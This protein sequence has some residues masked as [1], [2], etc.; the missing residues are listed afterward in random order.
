MLAMRGAGAATQFGH[1]LSRLAVLAPESTIWQRSPASILLRRLDQ[2]AEFRY[3]GDLPPDPL[4]RASSQMPVD[5]QAMV[6]DHKHDGEMLF[7]DLDVAG[8]TGSCS[9][10]F[11]DIATRHRSPAINQDMKNPASSGLQLAETPPCA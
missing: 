10:A 11:E 8:F 3:M 9:R 5:R 1:E 6:D 4:A 2:R 7:D